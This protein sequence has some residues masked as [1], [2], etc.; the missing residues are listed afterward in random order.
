MEG[1]GYTV[2]ACTVQQYKVLV[3][4]IVRTVELEKKI[5]NLG[6]FVGTPFN[7]MK[8]AMPSFFQCEAIKK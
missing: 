6:T 5:E 2:R 8:N 3:R 7:K 1:R 4:A